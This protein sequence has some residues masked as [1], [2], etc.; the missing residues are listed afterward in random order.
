M[1]TPKATW[2]Y[3]MKHPD[4]KLTFWITVAVIVLTLLQVFLFILAIVHYAQTPVLR[5][6]DGILHLEG[7]RVGHGT[8]GT[9]YTCAGAVCRCL[10]PAHVRRRM[11]RLKARLSFK[12]VQ[13]A[14]H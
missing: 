13:I 3:I 12:P 9:V 5:I 1:R 14:K 6:T 7:L 8:N 10:I 2:Q 4:E 11:P